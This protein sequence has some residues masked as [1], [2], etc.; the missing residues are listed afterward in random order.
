MNPMLL[1][2][3]EFIDWGQFLLFVASPIETKQHFLPM[4][5]HLSNSYYTFIQC[6]ILN[7]DCIW[8]LQVAFFT[9]KS[10]KNAQPGNVSICKCLRH[11]CFVQVKKN[12]VNSG[13]YNLLFCK[14]N[15]GT[16]FLFN[17]SWT[18]CRCVFTLSC[19]VSWN[20]MSFHFSRN[21]DDYQ[22][23]RKLGRG[24]Y[25]EVFE[26]INITNNEKVVVKILKVCR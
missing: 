24:K 15:R 18:W 16:S 21:Q 22:L 6:N 12:Q 14:R 3:G 23:V 5:V 1:N 4:I 19:F 17:I 11:P 8:Y 7:N 25:S 20:F 10:C 13:L 9:A 2:G 26:A